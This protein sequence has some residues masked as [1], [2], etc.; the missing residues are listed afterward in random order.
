MGLLIVDLPVAIREQIWHHICPSTLTFAN[1]EVKCDLMIYDEPR[2]LFQELGPLLLYGSCIDPADC[3][4][5]ACVEVNLPRD[6]GPKPEGIHSL[7]ILLHEVGPSVYSNI[8]WIRLGVTIK[9]LECFDQD[10]LPLLRHFTACAPVRR[11]EDIPLK[12]QKRHCHRTRKGGVCQVVAVTGIACLNM[13]LVVSGGR[14]RRS[15]LSGKAGS[16]VRERRCV[17]AIAAVNDSLQCTQESSPRVDFLSRL[18]AELRSRVF[19]WLILGEDHKQRRYWANSTSWMDGTRKVF[20]VPREFAINRRMLNELRDCILN[21]YMFDICSEEHLE[22]LRE[23]AGPD[24]YQRC[25]KIGLTISAPTPRYTYQWPAAGTFKSLF[26]R[27]WREWLPTERKAAAP[28]RLIRQL[29]IHACH[30]PT[31]RNQH[32]GRGRFLFQ[33]EVHTFQVYSGHK[34]LQVTFILDPDN[35]TTLRSLS[36]AVR[37][38]V[39]SVQRSEVCREYLLDLVSE[40]E[41]ASEQIL[42]DF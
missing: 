2:F 9:N 29:K 41:A 15:G 24:G 16:I 30:P 7:Q 22:L 12:L 28:G 37:T 38:C 23:L 25:R 13:E 18:P 3:L 14:V 32:N 21:N 36:S 6:V 42:Q 26:T 39:S 34:Q 4:R 40:I 19:Q 11:L 17:Q 27:L 35:Q 20:D 33:W 10:I 5:N 8:S 31:Y 1:K